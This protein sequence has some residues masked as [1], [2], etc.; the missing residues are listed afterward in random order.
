MN[1]YSFFEKICFGENGYP[2]SITQITEFIDS[3]K[4]SLE[5]LKH[6]AI[7]FESQTIAKKYNEETGNTEP[8]YRMKD[9]DWLSKN[10]GKWSY[11]LNELDKLVNKSYDSNNLNEIYEKL[12][13]ELSS[14]NILLVQNGKTKEVYYRN[15][16]DGSEEYIKQYY[17]N[18][19]YY[20]YLSD[21]Q[22]DYISK[23]NQLTNNKQLIEHYENFISIEEKLRLVFN[24]IWSYMPN[25]YS[26]RK[27]LNKQYPDFKLKDFLIDI[28]SFQKSELL[29]ENVKIQKDHQI[30]NDVKIVLELDEEISYELDIVGKLLSKLKTFLPKQDELKPVTRFDFTNKLNALPETFY[31]GYTKRVKFQYCHLEDLGFKNL[32]VPEHIYNQIIEYDKKGCIFPFNIY[33]DAF[34]KGLN[35]DFPDL[36]RNTDDYFYGTIINRLFSQNYELKRH[37]KNGKNPYYKESDIKELGFK[38]GQIYKQWLDLFN[39]E[40]LQNVIHEIILKEANTEGSEHKDEPSNEIIMEGFESQLTDVQIIKLFDLLN[41]TYIQT[42]LSNFQKIFK[43]EPLNDF[44]QIE[45]TKKFSNSLLAYFISE[46]FQKDNPDNYWNIAEHC[47]NV[48][49]LRQSYN[50]SYKINKTGKPKGFELIDEIIK[51]IYTPLQ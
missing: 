22:R 30:V 36:K 40:T 41:K 20:T 9:K 34:V 14:I 48:N 18:K 49:N 43:K 42:E 7:I 33:K 38:I 44:K 31:N 46:L 47:F 32:P 4:N 11:F 5:A 26:I 12:C 29:T 16:R 13:L 6:D 37:Y 8:I 39:D 21:L 25:G 45:K 10:C 27:D 15:K 35:S 2:I 1:P 28:L 23:V 17:D 3:H 51:T 50:N 19:P 24:R